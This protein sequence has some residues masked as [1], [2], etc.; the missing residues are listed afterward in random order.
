VTPGSSRLPE[1]SATDAVMRSPRESLESRRDRRLTHG[2]QGGVLPPRNGDTSVPTGSAASGRGMNGVDGTWSR[3]T[4]PNLTP[5]SAKRSG[6][7]VSYVRHTRDEWILTT[8]RCEPCP[9]YRLTHKSREHP[10]VGSVQPLQE[11]DLAANPIS[12]Q[13]LSSSG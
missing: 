6:R 5:S 3:T 7:G 2:R 10:G 13:S 8:K 9:V 11:S 1:A 4:S 12:L